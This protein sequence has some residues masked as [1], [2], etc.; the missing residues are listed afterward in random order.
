MESTVRY[1]FLLV[2]FCCAL[3]SPSIARGQLTF[4]ERPG[5]RDF[6]VDDAKVFRPEQITHIRQVCDRLLTDTATPIIVVTLSH[7]TAYAPH[8]TTLE[9]YAH[10][11]FNHWGIG[12]VQLHGHPWNTGI[13]VL[14]V[15]DMGRVR[16]ELGKGWGH[17][18]D[19]E[20]KRILVE[21]LGPYRETGDPARG[22]VA[23]VEALAEMA[24]QKPLPV[25]APTLSRPETLWL[26]WGG[27]A[28]G[29]LLLSVVLF[30]RT[31]RRVATGSRA[32][33][34]THDAHTY[35]WGDWGSRSSGSGGG[36]DGGSFGGGD[37]GGGG[38]SE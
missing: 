17:A 27:I 19:A 6:L 15:H 18:S 35:W 7:P 26:V 21:R 25:V 24:R 14:W 16:V 5:P 2:G 13:L 11:L 9:A 22:L 12:Q 32:K 10:A 20:V 36:F 3:G 34:T 33:G 8:D 31:R 23:T 4:P 28:G 37:S 30:V 29:V 1:M 38:A